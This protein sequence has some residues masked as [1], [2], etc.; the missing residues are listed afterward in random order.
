VIACKNTDNVLK[1]NGYTRHDNHTMLNSAG[2]FPSRNQTYSELCL[3]ADISG[4]AP[5]QR[6]SNT[7]NRAKASV[8]S[9]NNDIESNNIEI[10]N[11]Y[12]EREN[13][14][15]QQVSFYCYNRILLPQKAC[16]ITAVPPFLFWNAPISSLQ[17]SNS[18]AD[19]AVHFA[20][21]PSPARMVPIKKKY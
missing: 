18:A 13:A 8:T 4:V 3:Y 10:I 19:G 1:Y 5:G 11:N 14:W 2:I 21:Y 16:T 15:Q 6:T 17:T 7:L 9:I 20:T 12:I